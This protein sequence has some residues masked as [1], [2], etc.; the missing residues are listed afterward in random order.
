MTTLNNYKKENDKMQWFAMAAFRRE[1]QAKE[2][3]EECGIECFLPMRYQL[4]NRNGK[5]YRKL[6]PAIPTLVFVY[7]TKERLL[8]FKKTHPKLQFM[9]T[10]YEGKRK[11]ITIPKKQMESFIKVASKFEEDLIYFK[12]DELNLKAGT[13][14]RVHGTAFDGLEGTLIK[15]KGKR[16]KRV[17]VK[18]DDLVV[19]AAS[20]IDPAYISVIEDEDEED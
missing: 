18:I 16:R 1:K 6:L 17:V 12:L 2:E 13:K 3:L 10:T 4:V 7:S 5:K 15:I 20:E 11:I 19:V 9:T 8:L 14:V